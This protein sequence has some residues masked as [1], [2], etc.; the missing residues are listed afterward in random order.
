VWRVSNG[1]EINIWNDPWMPNNPSRKIITSRGNIICTKVSKLID[2][3]NNCWDEP[4]LRSLFYYVDVN[5]ILKI[6]LETGM[7]EDFVSWNFTKNGIFSVRAAYHYEW[8]HQH[9]RNLIR[10][11]GPG[12]SDINPV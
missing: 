8:D 4:M 9:G 2:P 5:I 12:A 11:S 10:T 3:D 6:P 1:E 7:M